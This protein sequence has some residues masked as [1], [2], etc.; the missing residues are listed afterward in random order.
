MF[1]FIL[2]I[3]SIIILFSFFRRY[4]FAFIITAISKKLF[5]QIQKQQGFTKSNNIKPKGTVT[6]DDDTPGKSK[7]NDN[8][9]GEYVDY[10]EVK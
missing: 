3:L 4:L 10:E 5:N 1:D 7:R 6:I 8:S 2:V 9:N